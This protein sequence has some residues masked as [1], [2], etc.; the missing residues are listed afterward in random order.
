MR[1]LQLLTVLAAIPALLAAP[2]AQAQGNFPE[3]PV[4]LIIGSAPGSGPDIISRMT[5]DR[6]Y[7][8]WKQRIV[9]DSRPG[10]AGAIS[11]DLTLQA[12]PDRKSVV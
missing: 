8:A 5:A 3:K 12:V 10:A 7:D 11:A 4:R 6:L 1:T 2:A 9:V